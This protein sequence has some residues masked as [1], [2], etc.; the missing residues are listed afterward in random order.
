[1]QSAIYHVGIG[2]KGGLSLAGPDGA[3]GES[4]EIHDLDPDSPGADAGAH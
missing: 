4:R 3:D 1:V 2:G